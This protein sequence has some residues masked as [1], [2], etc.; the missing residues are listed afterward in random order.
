M[1]DKGSKKHSK[2]DRL[3]EYH[4]EF[5]PLILHAI[6]SEW[7][8]K[9]GVDPQDMLLMSHVIADQ[10][11]QK[12]GKDA[13]NMNDRELHS[14]ILYEVQNIGRVGIPSAQGGLLLTKKPVGTFEHFHDVMVRFMYNYTSPEHDVVEMY[15]PKGCHE[16]LQKVLSDPRKFE[17]SKDHLTDEQASKLLEAA[18]QVTDK[19]IEKE[20]KTFQK[21]QGI[22][23]S[24]SKEMKVKKKASEERNSRVGSV[25]QEYDAKHLQKLHKKH[26]PRILEAMH[27]KWP[28]KQGVH[29]LDMMLASHVLMDQ[30]LEKLNKSGRMTDADI[31]REMREVTNKIP[32]RDGSEG[33]S[34]HGFATFERVQDVAQAMGD[35][36]SSQCQQSMKKLMEAPQRFG[37]GRADLSREESSTLYKSTLKNI[38]EDQKV[39]SKDQ[40]KSMTPRGAARMLRR[41]MDSLGKGTKAFGRDTLNSAENV[42]AKG[43]GDLLNRVSGKSKGGRGSGM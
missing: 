2:R 24:P 4:K 8:G 35:V 1:P 36:S 33:V 27:K 43:P 21:Q 30:M 17:I 40:E 7:A 22:E 20:R 32:R 31:E 39:Q 11:I 10:V 38:R 29:G 3:L 26:Q 12:H 18:Q 15:S 28:G 14:N 5:Q 19:D 13:K 16:S 42:L 23:S 9:G 6:E 34:N 37:I 41:K 25:S